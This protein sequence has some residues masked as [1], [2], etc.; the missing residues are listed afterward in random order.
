MTQW[1]KR[2]CD[3]FVREFVHRIPFS[4]K[5]KIRAAFFTHL[6]TLRKKYKEHQNPTAPEKRRKIERSHAADARKRR[7]FV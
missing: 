6:I 2:A 3:I 4:K 1:N 5:K 7:V